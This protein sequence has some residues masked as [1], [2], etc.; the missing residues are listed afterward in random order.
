MIN[1]AIISYKAN[2]F[3]QIKTIQYNLDMSKIYKQRFAKGMW[4][5]LGHLIRGEHTQEVWG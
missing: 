1:K 2:E 4:L 3:L 5:D